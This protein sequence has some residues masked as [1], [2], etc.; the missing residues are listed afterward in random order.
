MITVLNDVKNAYRADSVQKNYF[1]FFRDARYVL[2]NSEIVQESLSITESICSSGNFKVGLCESATASID[3]ALEPNV[4]GDEMTIVQTVGG[5]EPMITISD[6]YGVQFAGDG[7]TQLYSNSTFD[8]SGLVIYDSQQM[9]QSGEYYIISL[10]IDYIGDEIYIFTSALTGTSKT[11]Y[12]LKAGSF[13]FNNVSNW[14][15]SAQYV[16]GAM[17]K[18]NGRLYKNID[19]HNTYN[20]TDPAS[21]TTWEDITK[22]IQVILPIVGENFVNYKLGLWTAHSALTGAISV[23]QINVPVMP[24]GLFQIYECKR[25]NDTEIRTLRGYDRMQDVQLEETIVYSGTAGG[26]STIGYVLDQAA[27]D[28]QIRIGS[29][30]TKEKIE[31]VLLDED[32]EEVSITNDAIYQTGHDEYLTLTATRE[33]VDY[34]TGQSYRK[35][36]YAQGSGYTSGSLTTGFWAKNSGATLPPIQPDNREIWRDIYAGWKWSGNDIYHYW[37]NQG[38]SKAAAKDS[39]NYYQCW[40]MYKLGATSYNDNIPSGWTANSGRKNMTSPSTLVSEE[41]VAVGVPH[42]TFS[43]YLPYGSFT[44]ST[45]IVKDQYYKFTFNV[46]SGWTYVEGSETITYQWSNAARGNVPYQC[47][48][49]YKR[50]V[51]DDT[52][53]EPK[54]TTKTLTY[55]IAGYSSGG[56]Y[57]YLID[58]PMP[59]NYGAYINEN[60]QLKNNLIQSSAR[61]H[62]G[63]LELDRQSVV[64]NAIVNNATHSAVEI[65]TDTPYGNYG[66]F[67]VKYVQSINY[68]GADTGI[69]AGSVPS[70][71]V[72]RQLDDEALAEETVSWNNAT[73]T[74]TRRNVIA[75]YL[76][77]NGL[78]INFDRY[79]VSTFL[80]ISMS[81]LYPSLDLFPH[82]TG[83]YPSAGADEYIGDGETGYCKSLYVDDIL[84]APFD[85][86]LII[87][88]NP[89]SAEAPLYPFYYNRLTKRYGVVPASM[90][91]VG[92]WPGNKYYVI[93]SNF[94]IDNFVFSQ[95]QLKSICQTIIKRIGDLQ[96]FNLNADLKCLPYMEVGDSV[97]IVLPK[98]GYETVILRRTMSGCINQMD[99]YETNFY[100][101]NG[102]QYE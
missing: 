84:N 42:V 13:G 25:K 99:N 81:T 6:N 66:V 96:Y 62:N 97:N 91:E 45:E 9:F 49:R 41:A 54:L 4:K 51:V 12:Y 48:R 53:Y 55:G 31:T 56:I 65:E 20:T 11:L 70:I 46:P 76:E 86:V 40:F 69:V 75:S 21:S 19:I 71:V 95:N 35:Y 78:F 36:S 50:H 2:T 28:T 85:G 82:T 74:A 33:D 102:G 92:K 90:P 27:A 63:Y 38:N 3:V 98:G 57:S 61:R 29:N 37:L 89:S 1:V 88:S 43:A 8:A 39:N 93:K 64:R 32:I 26:T 22:R 16:Y 23:Y 52:W 73:I 94:F 83:I 7:V 15:N 60:A 24:L 5:F 34:N 17:V 58:V 10:S 47:T 44:Y 80:N 87:K 77:L 14:S 59:Q 68:T 100:E 67:K 30:R 72:T 79:G 18:R 101:D